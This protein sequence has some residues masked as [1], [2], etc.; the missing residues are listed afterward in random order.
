[1]LELQEPTCRD[2]YDTMLCLVV[3]EIEDEFIT[4]KFRIIDRI[5]HKESIEFKLYLNETQLTYSESSINSKRNSDRYQTYING[6][7][8]NSI[9]TLSTKYKLVIKSTDDKITDKV[10][11]DNA[12]KQLNKLYR[13]KECPPYLSCYYKHFQYSEDSSDYNYLHINYIRGKIPKKKY[14][15]LVLTVDDGEN[16]EQYLLGG[17][18]MSYRMVLQFI[19]EIGTAIWFLHSLG[20]CHRKIDISNTLYSVERKEFILTDYELSC[21]KVCTEYYYDNVPLNNKFKDWYKT[22]DTNIKYCY[23]TDIHAFIMLIIDLVDVAEEYE[24]ENDI[25]L[26]HII[27]G[28]IEEYKSRLSYTNIE[29][30][31]DI[32]NQEFLREL[33]INVTEVINDYDNGMDL[34]TK[35]TPVNINK[36]MAQIDSKITKLYEKIRYE[37]QDEII[38]ES[39]ILSD[40]MTKARQYLKDINLKYSRSIAE[41]IDLNDRIEELFYE[42]EGR[43]ERLMADINYT[44]KNYEYDIH[45]N[46]KT[47]LYVSDLYEDIISKSQCYRF[48]IQLWIVKFFYSPAFRSANGR[49]EREGM[50]SSTT[51]QSQLEYSNDIEAL[52]RLELLEDASFVSNDHH[53]LVHIT[54]YY[55]DTLLTQVMDVNYL[56]LINYMEIYVHY[57]HSKGII[58][59]NITV[60]DIF[61]QHYNNRYVLKNFY[62]SCFLPIIQGSNQVDQNIKYDDS[63][64]IC[65]RYYQKNLDDTFIKYYVN[66]D[67]VKLFKMN[68]TVY[69]WKAYDF[70]CLYLSIYTYINE[71]YPF[72]EGIY[73]KSTDNM[74][75]VNEILDNYFTNFISQQP[76][77]ELI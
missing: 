66:K 50:L 33:I 42:I 46:K 76:D 65:E 18:N 63:E 45:I 6:S 37:T 34:I 62:Y 32:T 38:N 73:Q 64:L 75:E 58:H 5:Y 68:L 15:D 53:E 9:L 27:N 43:Y 30:L 26:F 74:V 10:N 71:R 7:G 21:Y 56:D 47:Y 14:L 12:I 23:L 2:E 36:F 59:R 48:G 67:G 13:D 35:I 54:E 4:K 31:E 72:D 49:S 28:L 44:G 51:S 1:M 60:K 57:I 22:G 25:K 69:D 70:Y 24:G 20:I 52:S 77:F 8:T 17:G 16:I 61:Y 19:L 39:I 41:D 11:N 55:G 40:L 3:G 29:E